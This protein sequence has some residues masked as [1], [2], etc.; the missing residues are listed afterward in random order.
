MNFNLE[1]VSLRLK[2]YNWT[3]IFFLFLG[4]TLF[5]R[6][7]FFFRDYIDR[8]ESTF[9]L[10][11]QSIVD[12]HLPYMTLWDLKPPLLF[13]F[14]AA[15]IF[16]FGKSFIAIRLIGSLL[17][18]AS[19]MIVY[20][21]SKKMSNEKI[22][23]LGGLLLILT[24]S[25][26]GNIQGVMSEHISIFF[27][28]PALYFLWKYPSRLFGIFCAGLL[29]GCSIMTKLNMVYPGLLLGLFL[30]GSSFYRNIMRGVK[31]GVV[32]FL[33]TAT[34]IVLTAL[35]YILIDRFDVWWNSVI[36]A[37]I[38]YNPEG[39][40]LNKWVM[41]LLVVMFAVLF[42]RFYKK[43][44]RHNNTLKNL[45]PLIAFSFLGV[46]ISFID[47]G[48]INGHYLIQ[49]YPF[50]IMM[51]C[52]WIATL[53]KAENWSYKWVL[54]VLIFVTPVEAYLEYGVL[55]KR[56]AEGKSLYN[57]EGFEIPQY[58]SE[59]KIDPE[60][61]LF[62]NFH[63]GYWIM[64][65]NIPSKVMTHPSNIYRDELFSYMGIQEDTS[66]EEI[67]RIFNIVKPDYIVGP[68]PKKIYRTKDTSDIEEVKYFHNLLRKNYQ[69]QEIVGTAGIY[70]RKG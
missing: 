63:I 44:I 17:I 59:Q 64:D 56:L 45:Y 15:V 7:P 24:S 9:I 46:M 35:P 61:I 8:D 69:I 22:A 54:L 50:L 4:I 57:E 6:F 30:C 2:T 53:K 67:L 38:V 66:E 43:H 37:A 29:L 10:M 55:G 68:Q 40:P 20:V 60:N 19:A 18:V 48:K 32:L 12:G 34:T 27:Y 49:A 58:F 25:L 65:E 1:G 42:Y 23:L 11:G 3:A 14:F 16:L 21:I 47:V 36:M 26:F 31:N 33:G 70:K 62:M 28:L 13:Y 39:S 41:I 51:L 52:G 5:I